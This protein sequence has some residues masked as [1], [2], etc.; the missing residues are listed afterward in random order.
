MIRAAP[1]RQTTSRGGPFCMSGRRCERSRLVEAAVS[2]TAAGSPI[3]PQALRAGRCPHPPA[4]HT[5]SSR[6]DFTG[7]GPAIWPRGRGAPW[8]RANRHKAVKNTIRPTP[9][10]EWGR[11]QQRT[12]S[13]RRR[14]Q[15]ERWPAGR[16]DPLRDERDASTAAHVSVGQLVGPPGCSPGPFGACRFE[17]CPA[18]HASQA[19]W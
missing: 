8:H 14:T 16:G 3:R 9:E 10:R 18:H 19:L 4:H 12:A 15:R 13:G 5:T 11:T 7:T 17:S 2:K 6:Q 1:T